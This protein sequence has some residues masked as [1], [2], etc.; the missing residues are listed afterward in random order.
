MIGHTYSRGGKHGCRQHFHT[1]S[2]R[3]PKQSRSARPPK[4]PRMV[5]T[6]LKVHTRPRLTYARRAEVTESSTNKQHYLSDSISQCTFLQMTYT[7]ET[8]HTDGDSSPGAHPRFR[9]PLRRDPHVTCPAPTTTGCREDRCPVVN[10]LVFVSVR[11]NK[12]QHHH[13]PSTVALKQTCHIHIGPDPVLADH[14]LFPPASGS[15]SPAR[16]VSALHCGTEFQVREKKCECQRMAEVTDPPLAVAAWES[17]GETVCTL[18]VREM[19]SV[20]MP[21]NCS[22]SCILFLQCC[23]KSYVD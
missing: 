8:P 4:Q 17:L 14:A 22:D 1:I 18:L 23:I 10:N 20:C 6:F 19:P 12:R 2:A 7:A 15:H 11:T 16:E 13:F 9:P 3:P 21:I 5:R